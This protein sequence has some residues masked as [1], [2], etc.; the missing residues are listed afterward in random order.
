MSKL[1]RLKIFATLV[2]LLAFSAGLLPLKGWAATSRTR[3]LAD[4]LG[5]T[6]VQVL[7]YRGLMLVDSTRVPANLRPYLRVPLKG[8]T[9]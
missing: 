8:T 4:A 2:A 1:L 7:T 5:L 9:P 3:D 6:Q